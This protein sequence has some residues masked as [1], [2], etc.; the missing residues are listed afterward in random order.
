ME[1]ENRIYLMLYAYL[2]V[3]KKRITWEH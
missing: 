3:H 2:T 1:T